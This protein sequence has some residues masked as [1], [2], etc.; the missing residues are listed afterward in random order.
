M[1]RSLR[2]PEL[3]LNRI[4]YHFEHADEI[5][6]KHDNSKYSPDTKKGKYGVYS[7]QKTDG[8]LRFHVGD[9]AK[10]QIQES[11]LPSCLTHMPALLLPIEHQKLWDIERK[12][13]IREAARSQGFPDSF[14]IPVSN[15]QGYK[16]FS[17]SVSVPVLI[18]IGKKNLVEH[19]DL[20]V[21]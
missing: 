21:E 10:T 11:V 19:L 20:E 17:N 7:F 8:S 5:R 18:E 15:A 1:T 3:E 16:Q 6:V 13:S 9:P 2:L 4:K 12:L 14:R